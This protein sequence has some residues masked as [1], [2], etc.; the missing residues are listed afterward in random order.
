MVKSYLALIGA[1]YIA[2]GLW[3]AIRPEVASRKVGFDLLSGSGQ[4]EFTVVYGGLEFALGLLFLS[5]LIRKDLTE[6]MLLACAVIHICLAFFRLVSFIRFQ[7]I[8]SFTKSL[9]AIECL[10]AISAIAIYWY[11]YRRG[12]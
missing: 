6:P 5:P 8:Q 9:T 1:L 7:N 11:S 10:L 2:L 4:S 12:N 3:C